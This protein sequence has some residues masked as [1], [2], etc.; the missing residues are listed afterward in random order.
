MSLGS[1]LL[2]SSGALLAPVPRVP[3]PMA[4]RSARA[5]TKMAGTFEI[6][7]FSP[8]KVNI[9]LRI[10]GKT[11]D[12]FHESASLSQSIT[13]GDQ[14]QLAR[15]PATRDTFAGVVRPS[16]TTE[17]IKQHVEL[18]V[19]PTGIADLPTDQTNTVVR[20][21][22]VFRTRLAERDGGSLDVPR[23]RAHL[24]KTLPIDA[25]LGGAASNA[26]TALYGA[27]LLC[28][29]PASRA[30]LIA[31]A[32]ESL[33]ADVAAYLVGTGVAYCSGKGVFLRAERAEPRAALGAQPPRGALF[34]LAPVGGALALSTPAIFRKLAADGYRGL[35]TAVPAELLDACAGA[36]SF[37]ALL[38]AAA[39]GSD[40]DGDHAVGAAPALGVND[41]SAPA[42]ETSDALAALRAQLLATDGIAAVSLSGAG[43][44]LCALRAV[45]GGGEEEEAEDADAFAARLERECHRAC[46]VRVRAW[47]VGF[48]TP[49]EDGWYERPS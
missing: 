9:F 5:L 44:A 1:L 35:A 6:E 27:N 23:F 2:I 39:S 19:S 47:P 22:E 49:R 10:L 11:D 29:E 40:A 8:A 30:E 38:R 12:G 32:H 31:W 45:G 21:I 33:G 18:S 14:L 4:R 24:T 42:L 48:A 16:R 37:D 28:G 20:A 46:G 25:G 7:L 15:I 26:A 36:A 17:P 43:P 41:L 13:V 3:R 34:V